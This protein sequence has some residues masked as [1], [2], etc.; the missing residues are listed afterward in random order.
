VQAREEPL[1]DR[2]RAQLQRR[3]SRDDRRVEESQ[4]AGTADPHGRPYVSRP[5][6]G[7][8]TASSKPRDDAVGI[9]V[10]GLGVEVRDDAMAQDWRR[11]RPQVGDGHVIPALHQGHAP[12]R[13]E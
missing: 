12:C 13:R 9:D 10:L 2:P 5:L 11:E 1:D 6:F 7:P 4:F 8:G 3:Q